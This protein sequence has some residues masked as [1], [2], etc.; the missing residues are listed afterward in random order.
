MISSQLNKIQAQIHLA[1]IT[2]NRVA[3]SVN[4]LAV[5]KTKPASDIACAYRAGQR[6][7]GENYVQEALLKQDC[8]SAFNITWHFIGPIQ[9]NKTK[10]LA[11]KFDWVHSVDDMKIAQRLSAQRPDFLAPLNICIQVNISDEESKSGVKLHELPDLI[12]TVSTLPNLALR[13][14]MAI[15]S[16]QSNFYAQR[17]P[18]K[19]LVSTV[20]ALNMPELT[21]FSFGMSDDL[22]AAIAEGS[23]WVRIGTALFGS[24]NYTSSH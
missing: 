15:P 8:L 17:E 22:E 14:V 19:K 3:H 24:R 23:T 2:H 5:S 11:T 10:M 9:S 20:N 21:A 6:H 4:L 1:E 12:A 13:G 16:P 18:Y 7:F